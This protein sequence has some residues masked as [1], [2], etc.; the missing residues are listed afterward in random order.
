M[1]RI[2]GEV[3]GGLGAAFFVLAMTLLLAALGWS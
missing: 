1:R 2:V 3:I